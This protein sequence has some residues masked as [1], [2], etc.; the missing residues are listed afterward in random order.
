[1]VLLSEASLTTLESLNMSK[2]LSPHHV[3]REFG[4]FIRKKRL[5]KGLTQ[6]ELGDYL[7]YSSQY[8]YNWECGASSVPLNAIPKV[9]EILDIS[10]EEVIKKLLQLYKKRLKK[11]LDE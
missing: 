10:I 2:G 7:K 5:K 11:I 4:K 9:A 3:D 8:I 1:M 6:K